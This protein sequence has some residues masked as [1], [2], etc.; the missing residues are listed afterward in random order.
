[1]KTIKNIIKSVAPYGVVKWKQDNGRK[2]MDIKHPVE[3]FR[4]RAVIKKNN[5]LRNLYSDKR[6]FV[7][8]SGPTINQQPIEKLK[9]EFVFGV[10]SG[11]SHGKYSYIHP[12]FHCTPQYTYSELLTEE[13]LIEYLR[14]MDAN[15]FSDTKFFFSDT[16]RKVIEDNHIFKGKEVYYVSFNG[17]MNSSDREV[18]D[19]SRYIPGVTTVPIMAIMLAMYMGFKEIYLLGTEIDACIKKKYV[20]AANS[21][22]VKKIEKRD[23]WYSGDD[24]KNL[25]KNY[26]AWKNTTGML[27]QFR[28]L[29]NIAISNNIEIFNATPSG[30]VDEFPCVRFEDVIN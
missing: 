5:E 19:I 27:F 9:D 25:V 14:D 29:H 17:N 24:G 15:T 16:D 2:I 11:Y 4:N 18:Y 28:V 23:W 26:E 10:S 12:A 6:C 30:L 8:C 7:L 1:M 22:I 13:F 20:H 3:A 21:D